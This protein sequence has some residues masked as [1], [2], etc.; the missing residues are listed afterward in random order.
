MAPRQQRAAEHIARLPECPPGHGTGRVDC[1]TLCAAA[2]PPPGTRWTL[3]ATRASGFGAADDPAPLALPLR[4]AGLPRGAAE[5]E[6]IAP[7][8][9]AAGAAEPPPASARSRRRGASASRAGDVLC[10]WCEDVRPLRT[11]PPSHARAHWQIVDP[12]RAR[13]ADAARAAL[14]PASTLARSSRPPRAARRP[15]PLH[16]ENPRP[17]GAY[18]EPSTPSLLRTPAEEEEDDD[19]VLPDRLRAQ[20]SHTWRLRLAAAAQPVDPRA[21][22]RPPLAR[23]LAAAPRT[24]TS[25][26]P[27]HLP[28]ARIRTRCPPCSLRANGWHSPPLICAS[29]RGMATGQFTT[30]VQLL[31]Y[32]DSCESIYF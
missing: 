29:A 27:L 26:G 17:E 22:R 1:R 6:A 18:R 20:P 21:L 9:T 25:R 12:Q 14:A 7:Q 5:D 19:L 32:S 30:S 23:P 8:L 24:F 16:A 4:D 2:S 15:S 28:R 13:A 10:I 31:R 3:T 11:R